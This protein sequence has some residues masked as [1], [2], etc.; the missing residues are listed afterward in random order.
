MA[1]VAL[2]GYPATQVGRAGETGVHA[3]G[4]M[5]AWGDDPA[6]QGAGDGTDHRAGSNLL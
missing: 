2:G 6:C 1:M 4:S 3:G 5:A